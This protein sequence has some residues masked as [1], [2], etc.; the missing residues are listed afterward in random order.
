MIFLTW[1]SG[2]LA[3]YPSTGFECWNHNLQ[4]YFKRYMIIYV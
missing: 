4:N 2:A 3:E 1:L